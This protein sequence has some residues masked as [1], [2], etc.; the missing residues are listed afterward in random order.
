MFY[1]ILL[2]KAWAKVNKNFYNIYGGIPS[3][4]LTALTVF[5]NINKNF[6]CFDH[7]NLINEIENRIKTEGKLFAVN[8]EGHCHSL[9]VHRYYNEFIVFPVRNPWGIIG[10]IIRRILFTK[11]QYE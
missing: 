8:T 2:E 9:L 5:R 6:D 3:R 11:K 1:N 7:K 10:R 4:S